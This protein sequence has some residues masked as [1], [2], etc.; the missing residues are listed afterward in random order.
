MI[1][2]NGF[3]KLECEGW[4]RN[5]S[6]RLI[7]MTLCLR[8]ISIKVLVQRV[9]RLVEQTGNGFLFLNLMQE[10]WKWK[11]P[12]KKMVIGMESNGDTHHT[13]CT[14]FH[15]IINIKVIWLA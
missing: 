14:D 12:P 1:N 5:Y 6:I 9:Q 13:L 10:C 8:G 11:K 7:I 3:S 2:H 15:A 4:L